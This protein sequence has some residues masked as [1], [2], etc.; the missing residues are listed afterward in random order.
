MNAAKTALD[1][2]KAQLDI[3]KN[4]ATSYGGSISYF[5]K[6]LNKANDRIN[7]AEI[8][9]MNQYASGIESMGN[10][11]INYFKTLGQHSGAGA[12]IAADRIRRGV[13]IEDKTKH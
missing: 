7:S 4:S 8:S 11:T 3:I 5:E 6:E 1:N 12:N 2:A 9:A 13:K 10:K